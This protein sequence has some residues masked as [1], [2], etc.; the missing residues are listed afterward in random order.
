MTEEKFNVIEKYLY[1]MG[2]SLSYIKGYLE[3]MNADI[4]DLKEDSECEKESMDITP[5]CK[6][7]ADMTESLKFVGNTA[8]MD[9][10]RHQIEDMIKILDKCVN[11]EIE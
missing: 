6:A 11:G 4:K 7:I 1:D 3:G 8:V 2:G 5:I 9:I 10:I